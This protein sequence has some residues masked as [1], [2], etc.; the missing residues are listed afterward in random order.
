V[1]GEAHESGRALVLVA[2]KWDLLKGYAQPTEEFPDLKPQKAE[3]A[4]KGDL[5]RLLRDEMPFASYAP[6]VFVSAQTGEG[7]AELLAVTRRVADNFQR[8][9]DTGPLNRVIRTA[10]AKHAPPTRKGRA[11]KLLYC[12]QVRTG[13][14][15][16]ALFVND[17]SLMHVTYERYLANC[18]RR[19]FDF[20]GTPL[21]LLLRARR[22]DKETD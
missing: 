22:R 6:M 21:R 1:A 8:R 13:P 9:V 12:T 16:F 14:P 7:V 2:N 5:E 4:L 18:L 20:E 11:L 17:P 10:V 19:E 15:T 3:K